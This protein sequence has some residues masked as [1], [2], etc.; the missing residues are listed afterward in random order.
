M[1]SPRGGTK[2]QIGAI[3]CAR[4]DLTNPLPLLLPVSPALR[5]VR[6]CLPSSV[7]STTYFS[8]P[9]S[10]SYLFHYYS[11]LIVPLSLWSLKSGTRTAWRGS[12]VPVAPT[13]SVPTEVSSRLRVSQHHR[14]HK[15]FCQCDSIAEN[16]K[17]FHFKKIR[18]ETRTSKR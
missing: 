12:P 1:G 15:I 17:S 9:S 4:L 5:P 14:R 11:L 3:G 6:I 8:S 16:E 10:I 13:N 7:Y 2:K 18:L